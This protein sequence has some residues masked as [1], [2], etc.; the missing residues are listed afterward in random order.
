MPI[1]RPTLLYCSEKNSTDKSTRIVT[2]PIN[3]VWFAGSNGALI[4]SQKIYLLHFRTQ[5]QHILRCYTIASYVSTPC[6]V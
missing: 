1:F 3:L 5:C 4:S 2:V 6:L